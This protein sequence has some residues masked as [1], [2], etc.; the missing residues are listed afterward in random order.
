MTPT[1]NIF[2]KGCPLAP[3]RGLPLRP[4]RGFPT[5]QDGSWRPW[6][7]RGF[8]TLRSRDP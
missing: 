3:F 2:V 4:V 8:R 5:L 7:L 6:L 1:L